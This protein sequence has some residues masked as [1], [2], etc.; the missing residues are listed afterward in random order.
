MRLAHSVPARQLQVVGS[1]HPVN[2]GDAQRRRVGREPQFD[3]WRRRPRRTWRRSEVTSI[4]KR[5]I[6]E[7][8]SG[9]KKHKTL[10]FI[11]YFNRVLRSWRPSGGHLWFFPPLQEKKEEK[12]PPLCE[13][14]KRRK[15]G[16]VRLNGPEGGV[17]VSED[18]G[19]PPP[20]HT[21][22]HTL[23]LTS[24]CTGGET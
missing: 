5:C 23:K 2:A 18:A 4:K 9:L 24:H 15:M 14:R 12:W 10:F 16:R 22:T 13:N 11:F 3:G 7:I 19:G 20:P 6:V 8:N 1:V 21:H 17:P